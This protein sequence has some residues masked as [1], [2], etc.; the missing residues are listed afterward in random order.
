MDR[1]GLPARG[2][3]ALGWRPNQEG[4]RLSNSDK[5]KPDPKIRELEKRLDDL[6]ARLGIISKNVSEMSLTIF[7]LSK[8]F[9]Q[10]QTSIAECLAT[11]IMNIE[12]Q[13]DGGKNE[14]HER[15]SLG[16]SHKDHGPTFDNPCGDSN[17]A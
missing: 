8:S 16:Y 10:A 4:S 5:D 12:A 11:E 6:A 17:S 3:V 14:K 1:K 7:E 9:D 2:F 13:I 15:S